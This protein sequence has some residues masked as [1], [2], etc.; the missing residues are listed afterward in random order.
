[1]RGATAVDVA[2]CGV[3]SWRVLQ[4]HTYTWTRALCEFNGTDIRQHYGLLLHI[5][6]GLKVH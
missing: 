3:A 5:G 4:G 2:R 6:T 1:M